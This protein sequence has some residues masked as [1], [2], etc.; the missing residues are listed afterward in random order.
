MEGLDCFGA[1]PLA[2][3][4]RTG[5]GIDLN[6]QP[7]TVM[8]IWRMEQTAVLREKRPASYETT[9]AVTRPTPARVRPMARAAPVERSS[10]RPRM[11]GPRSLTVT[12]TL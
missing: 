6:L 1:S 10:T 9:S 2:M 4:V 5:G 7:S 11:N 12:I 3:T 8:H